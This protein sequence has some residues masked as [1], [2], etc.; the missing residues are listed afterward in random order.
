MHVRVDQKT[1]RLGADFPDRR[2]DFV[3]YLRVLSI[4][5]EDAIRAGEHTDPATGRVLMA[6]IGSSRTGEHVKIRGDFLRQDFDLGVVDSL[7]LRPGT[8][9]NGDGGHYYKGRLAR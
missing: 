6:R 4:D 1:N 8:Q 5:H 9:R 3:R 7:S 2:Q